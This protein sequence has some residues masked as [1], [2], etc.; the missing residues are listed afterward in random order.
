MTT[1]EAESRLL[2]LIKN[3]RVAERLG[4]DAIVAKVTVS[5]EE[6]LPGYEVLL[7]RLRKV[8]LI[9]GRKEHVGY[10]QH[11]SVREMELS[12]DFDGHFDRR[13]EQ[14]IQEMAELVRREREGV[15][16]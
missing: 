14:A 16:A 12:R 15:P 1:S 9:D 13:I 11:F 10:D 4:K 8:V 6:L 3:R 2:R 7:V 5:V